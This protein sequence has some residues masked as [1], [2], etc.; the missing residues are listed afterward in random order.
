[1][2]AFTDF[3]TTFANLSKLNS[4]PSTKVGRIREPKR[5]LP[6]AGSGSSA[7]GFV[8]AYS[9]SS[10]SLKR[11]HFDIL[12]QKSIPGSANFQFC[13]ASSL[14]S[15]LASISLV[16]TSPVSSTK[17]SVTNCIPSI[18]AFIKL[19][20]TLTDI[21][22]F[23]ILLRSDFIEINSETSGWFTSIDI[24]NAPLLPFCPIISVV[25]LYNSIKDIEPVVCLAE[26]FTSEPL[27]LSLEIS[28]P[29]P[30]PYE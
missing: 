5:Q 29:Q 13:L 6:P 2:R 25:R 26:L 8:P 1:M 9:N 14:K 10:S 17:N 4:F 15:F 19:A 18:T 27:G 28:T 3:C 12:S 30:P 16:T 11:F 24:I 20:S 22:A 7:H 21:F 23:C